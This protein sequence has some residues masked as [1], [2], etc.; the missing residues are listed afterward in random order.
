MNN[1]NIEEYARVFVYIEV[2]IIFLATTYVSVPLLVNALRWRFYGGMNAMRVGSALYSVGMSIF[3]G[4]IL[5]IWL[6]VLVLNRFIFGSGLDRVWFD[7]IVISPLT[8]GSVLYLL[9]FR[10]TI[11]HYK[12][13]FDPESSAGGEDGTITGSNSSDT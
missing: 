2:L 6:D 12:N 3:T 13:Q 9:A 5:L 1:T 8:I 4:W 11:R 10:N 7:M